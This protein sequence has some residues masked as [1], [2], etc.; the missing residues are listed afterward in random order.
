M[1][2]KERQKLIKW[3]RDY[4][5]SLASSGSYKDHKIK[6]STR[7]PYCFVSVHA[8]YCNRITEFFKKYFPCSW[9]ILKKDQ[10]TLV[11]CLKKVK[12]LQNREKMMQGVFFLLM[13]TTLFKQQN[14]H[15]DVLR[16]EY[17]IAVLSFRKQQPKKRDLVKKIVFD[18]WGVCD[19]GTVVLIKCMTGV[20]DQ[21]PRLSRSVSR[22]KTIYVISY[23][24]EQDIEYSKISNASQ[25]QLKAEMKLLMQDH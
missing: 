21:Y 16:F 10:N 17:A 23:T 6:Y 15:S 13:K 14:Q 3:Q 19:L 25:S 24:A 1:Q 9:R 7:K 4:L 8:A 20:V 12:L 2:L 5:Q 11:E 22:E 18:K